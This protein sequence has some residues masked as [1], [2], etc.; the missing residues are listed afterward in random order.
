MH[1]IIT[2][3]HNDSWRFMKLLEKMDLKEDD[4][5]YLLGDLFDRCMDHPD[6]AGVYFQV[7]KLGKKCTV[8]RGNHDH[9]LANYIFRYY[10]MDERDRALLQPYPYNSFHLLQER[11]TEVDLKEL[12]EY[13]LSWPVQVEIEVDGQPYLLAHACTAEPGKWKLDNYYG[14]ALRSHHKA[15]GN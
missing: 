2:D 14:R 10:G 15:N 8:I 12:A 3:I 4:H 11:L 5:L 1:Y 6:P 7:L 13:I 9:W